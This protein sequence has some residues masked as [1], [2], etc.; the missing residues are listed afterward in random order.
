MTR[1]L[2]TR[3]ELA[4]VPVTPDSSA[5]LRFGE[6][7]NS[8]CRMC[9]NTGDPALRLHATPELVRRVGVLR[10]YG[11]RRV[12][13]TGGE[14]TIHP[15]FWTVI[16]AM[17]G[18]GM[19]W[20]INTNGR[21]FARPGVAR[22]AVVSGLQRAI[23]S[24]HSL[25]AAVS[26]AICGT[27]EEA[28]EETVAGVARLAEAGVAVTLNCVVNRLNLDTLEEYLR[29][30]LR[31]F[32]PSVGFKLAFPTTIGRGGAWPEIATLRYADVGA[33]IR[34]VRRTA[35]RVGVRLFVESFPNCILRDA[36]APDLCRSAFGETHYLD[37]ASGEQ[38][39]AMRH[40]EAAL[41]AYS[42]AC[43]QCLVV[44]RC[45]G[46]PRTYARRYGVGELTPF[47]SRRAPSPRFAEG[48][49]P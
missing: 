6:Q 31:R 20:D 8:R 10:G 33:P 30:G 5:L 23:V 19:T 17:T 15:G 9:S 40:V 36:A 43:R 4:T 21:R 11:F 25:R 18:A 32:G 7:C 26:A 28:H 48:S 2:F 46:I 14:A 49:G 16:A 45:P 29:E 38:L 42:E 27:G 37:D 41:S 13:V 35:A 1:R 34:R 12:V 44:W 3:R 39:Y 47:G 24:L 22:R